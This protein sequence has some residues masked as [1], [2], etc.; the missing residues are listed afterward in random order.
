MTTM[1]TVALLLFLGLAVA[2]CGNS[3]D[4][5]SAA[6]DAGSAEVESAT[7]EDAAPTPT[8]EPLTEPM[9][10][11]KIEENLA[12]QGFPQDDIPD[13]IDCIEGES[14]AEGVDFLA[15][16][17]ETFTVLLVRCR[18]EFLSQGAATGIVPPPGVDSEQVTCT[19]ATMLRFIG[20]LP[21]AEA[22]EQLFRPSGLIPDEWVQGVADTCELS[23]EDAALVLGG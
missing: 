2:A 13:A 20:E 22:A 11:Q 12:N 14:D 4:A 9:N 7:D 10:V 16:D 15:A 5:E 8:T 21:L 23:L 6:T 1:R 17:N 18:P 19:G 3:D